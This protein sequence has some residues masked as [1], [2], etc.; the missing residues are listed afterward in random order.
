ILD[1]GAPESLEDGVA[2]YVEDREKGIAILE[3]G[4]A[5]ARD[6]DANAYEEA[7]AELAAQQKERQDAAQKLGFKK[8]SE[9][10]VSKEELEQQAQPPD[11]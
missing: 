10:L 3:D 1:L 2:K 11:G 4:L 9:P 6:D 5:A 7:Q 8:C